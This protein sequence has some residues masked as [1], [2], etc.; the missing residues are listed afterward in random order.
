MGKHLTRFTKVCVNCGKAEV[1]ARG[2]CTT[3]YH[4][5]RN[6]SKKREPA[7][8]A[9]PERPKWEYSGREDELMAAAA[10]TEQRQ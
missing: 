8:P 5:L 9:T 10:E 4:A 1:L 3:C 7:R 6:Q 2:F